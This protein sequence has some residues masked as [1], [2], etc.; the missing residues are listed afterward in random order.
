[1]GMPANQWITATLHIEMSN[2]RAIAFLESLNPDNQ[3]K[4]STSLRP[5]GVDIV[6]EDKKISTIVNVIDDILRCFDVF[7][8]INED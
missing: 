2:E 6:V 4:L 8:K 1:M 7:E 5:D 3:G